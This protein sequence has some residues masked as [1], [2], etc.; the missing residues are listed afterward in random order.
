ML[1]NITSLDIQLYHQNAATHIKHFL[2][3]RDKFYE[4]ITEVPPPPYEIVKF[5]VIWHN[6]FVNQKL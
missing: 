6:S 5:T 2:K 3:Y 4:T 1:R